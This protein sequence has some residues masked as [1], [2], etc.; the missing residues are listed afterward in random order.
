MKI[1]IDRNKCRGVRNCAS[2]APDVFDIDGEFKAVILDPK[3]DS[4]ETILKAA[5]F[6][7][8]QAILLDNE[9]S[10]KRIFP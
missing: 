5:K 9:E 2:I 3:G 6:C 8:V 7:P 4:D 10:G 1:T